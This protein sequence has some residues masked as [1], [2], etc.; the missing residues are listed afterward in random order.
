ML[1][2]SHYDTSFITWLSVFFPPPISCL[3]NVS[4]SFCLCDLFITIGQMILWSCDTRIHWCMWHD[5]IVKSY[6][7]PKHCNS[8]L[9]VFSYLLTYIDISFYIFQ[10]VQNLS[11]G[12]IVHD[13]AS[14]NFT[15]G[16]VQERLNSSANALELRLS[17]TNPSKWCCYQKL[18]YTWDEIYHWG[19]LR[20]YVWWSIPLPA[21]RDA[22]EIG[23]DEDAG[24]DAIHQWIQQSC[25][26][27][28]SCSSTS[29]LLMSC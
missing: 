9:V 14:K 20:F 7:Y 10:I 19:A 8:I 4:T 2:W 23:Q 3:L 27:N 1:I 12:N 29:V 17:C 5:N 15:D 6:H 22:M 24:E 21:F 11:W 13:F 28:A 26:S 25:I 16:L 18:T